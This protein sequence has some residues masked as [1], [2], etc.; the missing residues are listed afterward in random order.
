MDSEITPLD[1]FLFDYVMGFYK[2]TDRLVGGD[3]NQCSEARMRYGRL[4]HLSQISRVN[5]VEISTVKVALEYFEDLLGNKLQFLTER[6]KSLPPLPVV[7]NQSDFEFRVLDRSFSTVYQEVKDL[8]NYLDDYEVYNKLV[9]GSPKT[10]EYTLSFTK[11]SI[12]KLPF[13][14]RLGLNVAEPLY[15]GKWGKE[16]APFME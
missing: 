5:D 7:E 11:D 12:S 6:E 16:I 3:L 2:V 9:E 4:S 13:S 8:C 14:F 1:L 15:F 10:D